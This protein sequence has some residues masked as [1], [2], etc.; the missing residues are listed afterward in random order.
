[1]SFPSEQEHFDVVKAA[2]TAAGARPYDYDDDPTESAYNLLAV[3]D[4]FGGAQRMT[5]EIGTRS[6]YV[7]L[8][9]I[10][11]SADNAREMRRRHDL[12]LRDKRLTIGAH[13]STPVH[14]ESADPVRPSKDT[15]GT[16]WFVAQSVY[17]YTV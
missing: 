15:T 12:A 4:R 13:V 6:V 3:A 7:T 16:E 2:L 1:M 11:T 5:S 14:F 10:G 17:T 9:A 8:E